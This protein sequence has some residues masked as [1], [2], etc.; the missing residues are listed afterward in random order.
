MDLN[1]HTLDTT[2]PHVPPEVSRQPPQSLK[3]MCRQPASPRVRL[4]TV[5]LKA[6]LFYPFVI[7]LQQLSLQ[8]AIGSSCL[9]TAKNK[10]GEEFFYT[11][12]ICLAER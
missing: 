1:C 3:G 2:V 6:D 7:L 9:R 8:R 5:D 12:Y 4:R 10:E 11:T